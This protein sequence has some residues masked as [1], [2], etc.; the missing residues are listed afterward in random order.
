M[1]AWLIALGFIIASGIVG[2]YVGALRVS[3]STAG[4]LLTLL[5]LRPLG[6]L[7]GKLLGLCGL[8]HPVAM[9]ILGPILAF[10]L[11]Q[12]IFKVS[13]A[14]VYRTADTYYKYKA[15]DTQRL[16]FERMN[17][18]VGPCLGVLNGALYTIL[19]CVLCTGVGYAT[20]QLSRGPEKDSIYLASLNRLARDFQSSGLSR[21]VGAYVP[22]SP[23]Y[24]DGVD[25]FAEWFH[26]PLV[27]SRLVGY[28]PLVVLADR[29][30][31]LDLG[32]NVQVQEFL[33]KG[34]SIGDIYDDPKL[35]AVLGSP[36]ILADARKLLE[37]DI[38]DLKGY[39]ATGKSE[40][41]DS[42]Q[43]L[44]RWEFNLFGT[45]AENKKARRMSGLEVNKMRGILATQLDGMVMLATL[46]NQIIVKKPG[47]NNTPMIRR[48]ASWKGAGGGKY[49][50]NFPI[51]D[52][53][54]LDLEAGVEGR[55]LLGSLL[56][57]QIVFER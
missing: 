29:R 5:F 11:V 55:R 39:L 44:G 56:G 16:L 14:L 36:E 2:F 33:L 31:F 32:N 50:I 22:A 51:S 47:A 12:V 26:Q 49:V 30:E 27:Q 17:Q 37:N 19:I 18:R 43:I 3:F 57:Y 8:S 40:K 45:I 52:D 54:R 7:C 35:M 1:F 25:L 23:V 34:P 15:S 9:G 46:D 13:G 21:A 4:L 48:T 20:V 53:K 41:Y 6:D 38:A 42:E 24:Y 28:P 10:I